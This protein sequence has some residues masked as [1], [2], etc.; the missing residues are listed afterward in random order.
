LNARNI[1]RV[2]SIAIIGARLNI[3]LQRWQ[4]I[5]MRRTRRMVV[6]R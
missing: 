6:E 2:C 3:L 4:S 1:E 5:P